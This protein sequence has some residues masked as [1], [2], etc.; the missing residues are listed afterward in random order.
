[1]TTLKRP[2]K[3]GL[4]TAQCTNCG[5]GIRKHY[6][7]NDSH[8]PVCSKCVN[9]VFNMNISMDELSIPMKWI[10]LADS[11]MYKRLHLQQYGKVPIKDVHDFIVGFFD[12]SYGVADFFTK[13]G[14]HYVNEEKLQGGRLVTTI[15][16]FKRGWVEAIQNHLAERYSQIVED[17]QRLHRKLLVCKDCQKPLYYK[18]EKS[19]DGK[20]HNIYRC[21]SGNVCKA[22]ATNNLVVHSPKDDLIIGRIRG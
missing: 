14:K 1:M 3:I 6:I 22:C 18:G 21:L 16:L 20:Y 2:Y 5:A 9:T 8:R 11:Y 17:R 13:D 4:G 12:K 15:H 19:I 10:S 7:A